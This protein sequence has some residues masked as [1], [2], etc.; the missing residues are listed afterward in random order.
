MSTFPYSGLTQEPAGKGFGLSFHSVSIT[1][2]FALH[3][4]V[5]QVEGSC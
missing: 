5:L 1:A 4:P 3:S 2:L